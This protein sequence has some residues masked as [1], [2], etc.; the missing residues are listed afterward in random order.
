MVNIF[1]ISLGI[2][3]V[4]FQKLL[5]MQPRVVRSLSRPPR[6]RACAVSDYHPRK[7]GAYENDFGA[8]GQS[9]RWI[10]TASPGLGSR[11][12]MM[13]CGAPAE[14]WP[15]GR[16]CATRAS[17]ALRAAAGVTVEMSVEMLVEKFQLRCRDAS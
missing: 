9:R 5:R 14:A 8:R 2:L 4:S 6:F 15:G 1:K 3:M 17:T 7:P 12:W 13:T 16:R 11:S 10:S